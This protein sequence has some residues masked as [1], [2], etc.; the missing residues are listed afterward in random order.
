MNSLHARTFFAVILLFVLT[1]RE[2]RQQRY[3]LKFRAAMFNAF[4]H[5]NLLNPIV[6]LTQSTFGQIRSVDVARTMQLALRFHF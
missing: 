4:N 3:N 6:E 5:V 1:H 2:W